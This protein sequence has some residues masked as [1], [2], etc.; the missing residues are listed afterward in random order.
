MSLCIGYLIRVDLRTPLLLSGVF[1]AFLTIRALGV[2]T[3]VIFD[4][5]PSLFSDSLDSPST[6]EFLNDV[7]ELPCTMFE[8]LNIPFHG[9][10]LDP[11]IEDSCGPLINYDS[12]FTF[13]E[14]SPF[15]ASPSSATFDSGEYQL[16]ISSNTTF[17]FTCNFASGRIKTFISFLFWGIYNE[18]TFLSFWV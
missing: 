4:S 2:V 12:Y 3:E 17:L 7:W 1:K 10:L 5:S 13:D 16:A 18:D 6:W 15:L 14:T 11:L 8:D 9:V